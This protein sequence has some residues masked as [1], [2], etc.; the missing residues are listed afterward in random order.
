MSLV[1][2]K[3]SL[4]K[5]APKRSALAN[6]LVEGKI[7]DLK[8][9]DSK[10][11][12]AKG[13]DSPN[14]GDPPTSQPISGTYSPKTPGPR[15]PSP[16][17]NTDTSEAI[18]PFARRSESKEELPLEDLSLYFGENLPFTC[19]VLFPSNKST[20]TVQIFEPCTVGRLLQ[21]VVSNCF[22]NINEMQLRDLSSALSFV[23]ADSDGNVDEDCPAL[24]ESRLIHKFG[25]SNFL[26]SP[27]YSSSTSSSNS[28]T[29]TTT[30]SSST[31]EDPSDSSPPI[32]STIATMA[33]RNPAIAVGSQ[34]ILP[35]KSST[36]NS[37]TRT[38][39]NG[40]DSVARLLQ[41]AEA[42]SLHTVQDI[43]QRK[44]ASIDATG[45]DNW[46][47]LHFATRKGHI[48]VVMFAIKVGADLECAT[49]NGWTPLHLAALQGYAE[50]TETLLS[51]GADPNKRDKDGHTPLYYA[52]EKQKSSSS[53]SS[54]STNHNEDHT[55]SEKF[56]EV[57]ETLE[58]FG[59]EV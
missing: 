27:K 13:R 54:S 48:A 7:A 57:V 40:I 1:F 35:R 50:I 36:T 59:G 12:E 25:V 53:S 49:K 20:L 38:S 51:C 28:S 34:K 10:D 55:E 21:Q 37:I 15:N 30:I 11:T 5:E 17:T 9:G 26:I 42:G 58:E 44:L 46:T 3:E 39:G 22:D 8:R 41:A 31:S 43:I 2:E 24:D 32:E 29:S 16:F 18:I 47:C 19:Q 4:P 52:R 33:P 14:S 6:L 56:K 45:I 23:V